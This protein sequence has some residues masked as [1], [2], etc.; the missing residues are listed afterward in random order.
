MLAVYVTE[1]LA[2]SPA[3][4]VAGSVPVTAKA[5]FEDVAASITIVAESP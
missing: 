3:P 5:V 1:K 4:N 2:D